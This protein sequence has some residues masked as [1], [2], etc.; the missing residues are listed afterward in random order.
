MFKRR[1]KEE[2]EEEINALPLSRLFQEELFF[3]SSSYVKS[4]AWTLVKREKKRR[5]R[6][7]GREALTAHS[8]TPLINRVIDFV[9]KNRKKRRELKSR[10]GKMKVFQGCERKIKN[11][12]LKEITRDVRQSSSTNELCQYDAVMHQLLASHL[13]FPCVN[14]RRNLVRLQFREF[15]NFFLEDRHR[16]SKEEIRRG[17]EQN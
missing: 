4:Y 17:N 2:E 9:S 13:L 3:L 7:I 15:N 1:N 11:S 10:E 5:R 16:L 14:N 6:G 12:R 8:K